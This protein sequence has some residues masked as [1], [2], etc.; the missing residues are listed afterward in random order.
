MN[1]GEN[2]PLLTAEIVSKFVAHHKLD[3]GQPSDL[4][5]TVHRTLVVS[6]N[7]T[8]LKPHTSSIGT[9][10]SPTQLCRLFG[11]WLPGQDTAPAYRHPARPE[12]RRIPA[13]MGP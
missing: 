7:L 8:N 5:A 6:A 12:P 13:T 2:R 10:I 9:S 3:P 4:I 1:S 11:L